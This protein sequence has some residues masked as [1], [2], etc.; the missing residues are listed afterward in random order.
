MLQLISASAMF[1]CGRFHLQEDATVRA[2]AVDLS[3][4]VESGSACQDD[5]YTQRGGMVCCSSS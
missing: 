3:E 4:T 2:T 1:N 5:N